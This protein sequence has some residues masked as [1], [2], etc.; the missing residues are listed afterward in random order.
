M[1]R[2]ILAAII[3]II[4][5]LFLYDWFLVPEVETKTEYITTI[6]TKIDTV[7]IRDTVKDIRV[8][9]RIIRDTV[10][11]NY[12]PKIRAFKTTYNH[13]YGNVTFSGEVLGEVLKSNVKS[14][15]RTTQ[16]TNTIIKT[17][18]TTNTIYNKGV[19]LGGGIN[20]FL[21]PNISVSYIDK[22]YSFD[23]SYTPENNIHAIGI[24]KK[25]F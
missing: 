17:K 20:S 19:Y 11:I 8:D 7:Y 10:L 4:I 18:N 15:L 23:Y 9:Q 22:S 5:G 12:K 6:E 2:L 13:L 25:I 16:T 3:G 21:D 1:N 14:D 24:K